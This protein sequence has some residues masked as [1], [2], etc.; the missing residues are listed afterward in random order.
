MAGAD[1]VLRIAAGEI[2]TTE[3]PAGSNRVEYAQWY[4]MNGEPWCAM[5]VSW[6]FAMAGLLNACGGKFAYCPYWVNYAKEHDMW[7][8]RNEKPQPGD[9]I[10][11]GNGSRACHVGIVEK[12]NG[13]SSVTTIEGN[14]SV[15]SNDNGGSVMRRTRSY[16]S[17]G[18]S[19]Y[20]LG[21]MRPNFGNTGNG[22]VDISKPTSPTVDDGAG[23]YT[24]TASELCV[25]TGA[26]TNY[27]VKKHSELTADGRAHDGDK[28]GALS[29]GTRATV[30]QTKV[31]RGNTWGLIPSGWIC[32][33]YNGKTYAVK[34]STGG[35]SASSGGS[36][37]SPGTYTITASA[38]NVR[39]GAGTS[40]A[41]KSKSQLTADGRKHA[42]ANGSLMRG[43]R[44]TVS[45]VKNAGYSVWGLI[46]SGW[47]CLCD[48]GDAYVK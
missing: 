7:L 23:T 15:T 1:D 32:L 6:V 9:I 45:Q 21:F 39:T 29:K 31:V 22:G 37:Y 25:R 11:F 36:A 20:I 26:G 44:V 13:S 30:S 19:W 47:I 34:G 27:R 10:F 18:S 43:T 41:K 28:D 4:G 16:G 3:S 12:R 38:L 24:I 35:S 42:N 2:G 40:Y 14:T 17:V 48:N 33:C 8:D 5:F 46:P